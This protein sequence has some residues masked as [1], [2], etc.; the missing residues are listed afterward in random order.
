MSVHHRSSL[1]ESDAVEILRRT[2]MSIIAAFHSSGKE[3]SDE[4]VIF[5]ARLDRE[6][7]CYNEC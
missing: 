7:S 6:I 2:L 4:E 1:L 5:V 3:L